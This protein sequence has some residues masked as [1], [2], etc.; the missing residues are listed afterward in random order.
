MPQ[1]HIG[2]V[3]IRLKSDSTGAEPQ[4][5]ISAVDDYAGLLALYPDLSLELPE[6]TLNFEAEDQEIKGQADDGTVAVAETRKVKPKFTIEADNRD[7]SDEFL[8]YV[9]GKNNT[10]EIAKTYR[11]W[12]FIAVVNPDKKLAFAGG[13]VITAKRLIQCYVTLTL[14]GASPH[15]GEEPSNMTAYFTADLTKDSAQGNTI[16]AG[17]HSTV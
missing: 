6:S 13:N 12:A 1:T 5:D 8:S 11:F 15:N 2:S 14:T 10:L 9:F 3:L 4:P 7:F 16:T 17:V